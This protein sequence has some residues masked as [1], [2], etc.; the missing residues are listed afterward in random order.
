VKI[1][2]RAKLVGGLFV[3]LAML[4]YAALV[5]VAINA[6]KV[7][8]GVSVQGFDIGGLSR[9]DAEAALSE[10]GEEMQ[11]E[12]MLFVAEGFDCRF[13]PAMVGWGPQEFQTSD[14]A[15]QV[16]RGEGLLDAL[17]ERWT[18]WTS[19]IEV[20]W[21]DRPNAVRMG[22]ELARC[23]RTARGLG[24]EIDLPRLRFLVKR[25]ITTWPREP[26]EIPVLDSSAA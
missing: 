12:P 18:A 9:A 14:L 16:G 21:T 13:S 6:G 5:E 11:H 8:H 4:A 22:R 26:V 23:D 20:A 10:R 17:G 1:S 25:T 19:G 3:V 7:H 15:M 24:Y 2:A